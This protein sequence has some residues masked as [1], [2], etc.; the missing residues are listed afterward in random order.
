MGSCFFVPPLHVAPT[1][2]VEG[3]VRTICDW[4]SIQ[5]VGNPEAP[6]PPQ[7]NPQ[8]AS[9]HRYV[10]EL[11]NYKLSSSTSGR[12]FQVSLDQSAFNYRRPLGVGDNIMGYKIEIHTV[13]HQDAWPHAFMSM[14][15]V[16]SV[17]AE[18]DKMALLGTIHPVTSNTSG[19]GG[20][21]LSAA[22]FLST[23]RIA[24]TARL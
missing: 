24:V 14:T 13:P 20:G 3:H 2:D 5:A 17:Q 21:G 6:K 12:P 22:F 4:H 7:T 19:G 18:V 11:V 16:E 9:K 10:S 8:A 1:W 15:Q 23:K